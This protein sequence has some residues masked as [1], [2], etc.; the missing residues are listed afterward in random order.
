MPFDLLAYIAGEIPAP[1]PKPSI[2]PPLSPRPL[3]QVPPIAQPPSPFLPK[4]MSSI[5]SAGPSPSAVPRFTAPLPGDKPEPPRPFMGAV[6]HSPVLF[7]S[8]VSPLPSRTPIAPSITKPPP[9]PISHPPQPPFA[10]ISKPPAPPSPLPRPISVPAGVD[11]A[12]TPPPPRPF[13]APLPAPP[14]RPVSRVSTDTEFPTLRPEELLALEEETIEPKKHRGFS[15]SLKGPAIAVVALILIA[16]IGGGAYRLFFTK[17]EVLSPASPASPT[18]QAA[19]EPEKPA[20]LLSLE[21]SVTLTA[22]HVDEMRVEL[23]E[24]FAR[25][26]PG[27]IPRTLYFKLE[28]DTEKRYLNLS[29]SL[30][31]IDVTFPADAANAIDASRSTIFLTNDTLDGS[32]RFGIAVSVSGADAAKTA[33][34]QWEATMPQEFDGLLQSLGKTRDPDQMT[35]RASSRTD[36]FARF[37]NYPDANLSLDYA[38]DETKNALIIATSP[39]TLRTALDS[40][41]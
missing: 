8:S 11:K 27:G 33:M 10:R 12:P 32:V 7:P 40:L 25:K 30:S 24:L 19:Q 9:S 14:E 6:P 26:E 4:P 35:F 29:E 2:S 15:F 1:L 16:G 38:I 22:P 41:K 3:P 17:D 23:Q 31:L 21:S 37:L 36:V 28:S 18:P 39:A 13:A 34:T 20:S 5:P